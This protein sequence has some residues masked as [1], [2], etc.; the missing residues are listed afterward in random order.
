MRL[1]PGQSR[2]RIWCRSQSV[3]KLQIPAAGLRYLVQAPCKRSGG[4]IGQR[5]NLAVRIDNVGWKAVV[6]SA[7][8]DD[9]AEQHRAAVGEAKIREPVK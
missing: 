2:L 8:Y 9:A 3:K 1:D 7:I 6:C 5:C 4:I